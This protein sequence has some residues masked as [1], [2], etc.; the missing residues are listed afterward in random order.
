MN[1]ELII[2]SFNSV[3]NII[4]N[5]QSSI[6]SLELKT[7]TLYYDSV[8]SEFI[9]YRF[10]S[11][12]NVIDSIGSAEYIVELSTLINYT[13]MIS[14]TY[15]IIELS[16]LVNYTDIIEYNNISFITTIIYSEQTLL[17]FKT[18][19]LSCV[20]IYTTGISIVKSLMELLAMTDY[21]ES[22][23]D[24]SLDDLA[25]QLA[26]SQIEQSGY[27]EPERTIMFRFLVNMNK[28]IIYTIHS[29]L[30]PSILSLIELLASLISDLPVLYP[31]YKPLLKLK[32]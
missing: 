26:Q 28:I 3:T 5:T 27:T 32:T 2:F 4:D 9:L 7:N 8:G 24:P 6:V 22:Y 15:S 12:V 30:Q 31:P 20:I 25:I 23:Y 29:M 21:L 11:N 16:T 14:Y 13:D 1:Y 19:D 18:Y 10:N 17:P